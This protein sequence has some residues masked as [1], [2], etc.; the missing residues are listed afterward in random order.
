MTPKDAAKLMG[1]LV[2]AVLLMWW[3]LRGTEPSAL[4]AQLRRASLPGLLVGACL[5]V[6]HIA[7]RAWRWRAL[8]APC[9]ADV[10][11][12]SLFAAIVVGYMTTWVVPGRLGELVRPMLISAREGLDLG[13]SLGTVVADRLLDT[14]TVVV[15]FAVG[16][17]LTPLQ[18]A[19]ADYATL[20]RGGAAALVAVAIGA[21]A[22]MVLASTAQGRLHAWLARRNRVL[23]WFGRAALSLS[24]GADA[25]RSPRQLWRIV[26]YS[27]LAWIA[28]T[29]ATWFGV[30]AAGVELSPQAMLVI[31]PML[32]LGVAVPTPGGAG[33]YHGAMKVGLTL[34]GVAE[35]LAVSAGLLVHAMITIPFIALG[36]LTLWTEEISWRDLVVSARQLRGLGHTARG[37]GVS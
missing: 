20:I 28:I 10:A 24:S 22:L 26:L 12:R 5:N 9:R 4:W 25:L 6:A 15:L 17:W 13:P 37:E 21:L 32:V 11:F 36:V 27:L 31:L 34:F 30:R 23:R 8:L 33:S 18:G 19:A 35:V 16:S 3:V 14:G 7:F 1:G 2:L 29:G